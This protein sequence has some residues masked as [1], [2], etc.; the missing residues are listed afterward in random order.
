[1]SWADIF[2]AGRQNAQSAMIHESGMVKGVNFPFSIAIPGSGDAASPDG[3]AGCVPFGLL[4]NPIQCAD[5]H[6]HQARD[7][8]P[9]NNRSIKGSRGSNLGAW[10]Q[11]RAHH[12]EGRGAQRLHM[13]LFAEY[14][15]LYLRIT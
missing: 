13:L 6:G 8:W 10:C 15:P 11:S 1:M 14:G 4:F 3:I 7:R 5:W 12:N 9:R 2:V